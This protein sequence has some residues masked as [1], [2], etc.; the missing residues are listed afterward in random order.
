[1]L[2]LHWLTHCFLSLLLKAVRAICCVHKKI[3]F[4]VPIQKF[5]IGHNHQ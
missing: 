1:M 2:A 3:N 4:R 5:A